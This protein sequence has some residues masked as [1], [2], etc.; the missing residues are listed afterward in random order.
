ME[1]GEN[2]FGNQLRAMRMEVPAKERAQTVT[3]GC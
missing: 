3:L 2:V 1:F